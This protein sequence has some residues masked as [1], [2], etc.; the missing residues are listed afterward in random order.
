MAAP[1]IA[2]LPILLWP[3]KKVTVEILP[4]RTNFHPCEGTGA[5]VTV[6]RRPAGPPAG[7]IVDVRRGW[8]RLE[9]ADVAI[10]S[11]LPA[12][13]IQS[14]A[15]TLT[16]VIPQVEE[17]F[18]LAVRRPVRLRILQTKDEFRSETMATG[19]SLWDRNQDVILL[20]RLDT[21]TALAQ[22]LH[23]IVHRSLPR[24]PAWLEE[25]LA[26]LAAHARI[27]SATL[28]FDPPS[29]NGRLDW[30]D[31]P[32]LSPQA[33]RSGLGRARAAS[34]LHFLMHRHGPWAVRHLV[35]GG[36]PE[37]VPGWKQWAEEEAR[38]RSLYR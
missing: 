16:A 36:P 38:V 8:R 35:Q 7:K 33:A 28:A 4:P 17:A 15:R 25:G 1:Y 12:N 26:E 9:S 10:E 19:R 5:G 11:N 32:S 29:V 23:W 34:L 14:L 24:A 13:E 6:A 31:V 27:D 2:V 3:G 30:M 22:I 18:G 20:P 21:A 37:N